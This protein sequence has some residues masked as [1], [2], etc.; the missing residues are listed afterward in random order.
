MPR[1]DQHDRSS[2]RVIKKAQD[3]A[4]A[5]QL[6]IEGHNYRQI[7]E[8]LGI[9]ESWAH[10]LVN[11]AIDEIPK[12]SIDLVFWREAQRL[13]EA[14]KSLYPLMVQGDVKA[15]RVWL[16]LHDRILKMF[17]L[18]KHM[19]TQQDTGERV[20]ELMHDSVTKLYEMQQGGEGSVEAAGDAG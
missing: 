6:R 1:K 16:D 5:L 10:Q 18:D 8:K 12:E 2:P 17:H 3:K 7:S 9:A 19:S 20:I 4:K 11:E 13:E 14:A 15:A